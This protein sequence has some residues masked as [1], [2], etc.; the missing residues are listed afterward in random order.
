[1]AEINV[2]DLTT[3]QLTGDGVFDQ[4]MQAVQLRLEQEFNSGRINATDYAKVYLGAL[5]STMSQSMQFVLQKEIS[6]NQAKLL[7]AQTLVADKQAELVCNQTQTE[8]QQTL[9]AKENVE[10]TKAERDLIISNKNKVLKETLLVDVQIDLAQ[11]DL[12]LKDLAAE[13]ATASIAHTIAQKNAVEANTTLIPQQLKKLIAETD[14]VK[15]QGAK[16]LR[17]IA[18]SLLLDDKIKAEITA[19]QKNL[20]LIDQQILNMIN[21]VAK[22][23]EEIELVKA[24]VVVAQEEVKQMILRG[25][26]VK[27]ET[28]VIIKQ[29]L[30]MEE[31]I[32]KLIEEVQL[33][34]ANKLNVEATTELVSYQG[35][36]V[37][38]ESKLIDQKTATEVA[39][40]EDTVEGAPVNGLVG[41]QKDLYF[42]QT[43]G[44][45]R[46]AEQKAAKIIVDT[47]NVRRTSDETLIGDPAGLGDSSV[48]QFVGA[49]KAGIGA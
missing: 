41:R 28:N 19:A 43:E 44:F 12:V 18:Q 16:L 20:D 33:V 11:K 38:S 49:L 5:E 6:S 40:T 46:D 42:A 10:N 9:I 31:E 47:W 30:I 17:D 14:V 29:L 8:I 7:A 1:M 39:Q 27:A 25:Q 21:E 35:I 2:E 23:K 32:K 34:T 48:A 4:L 15:H 13:Q 24:Q 45:K 37:Q 36:K 22:S 26:K 3:K